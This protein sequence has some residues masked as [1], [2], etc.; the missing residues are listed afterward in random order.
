MSFDLVVRDGTVLDGTGSGPVRA[1]VGIRGERIEAVAPGLAAAGSRVLDAAGLAVAPGFIDIHAHGDVYPLICPDAPARLHDGVT[2]EIIGNCGGSA[3]PQSP[4]MLAERAESAERYGIVVDWATLDDFARRQDAIGSG[5]N[6]GSLVGHGN[7]RTA[8]LGEVDRPATPDELVAMQR[9]VGKALDAGA[10]GFSTGLIYTPGMYAGPEEIEALAGVVARCGA[11]YASH[12]RNEGDAIEQAIEEFASVGR[13]TGV[14]LQLSHAKVAGEP[15]WGKADAVIEQIDGIRAEGIDLA[16]DRYPYS[17]SATSLSALRPGWARAGGR[18]QMLERIAAPASRERIL[19]S[20]NE[21]LRWAARWQ[22]VV[23]SSTY[24][25][26]LR[27]AEGR[28]VHD[29]AQAAGREPA[30]MALE[31]LTAG[32]GRTSIV[33]FSMCEANIAKWYA[34]PYTA[35]GSDSS[36]RS[37]Q[38]PTARGKP[39]P[40]TY[41][42]SA[43]FLGRYVREQGVVPL[44]EGVRRLTGLPASRLGLGRRGVVRAGAY[45]DV[46]VFDPAAIVDRATYERPQQFSEGVRHVVVNGAVALEDGELTGV[47]NGRF[48]RRGAE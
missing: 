27:D 36:T 22:S 40:R 43:R 45:A 18:E 1:D 21:E 28:S 17:A 38:G 46:T 25:E 11:L 5:I 48:L 16:C 32:G 12:I 15:N 31:L 35:V 34:L 37:I 20:L 39:H 42:T 33:V 13:R 10:F 7:V 23:I 14:R 30:E 9:E 6:R 24:A 8:V 3:F 2:T 47:R 4:E 29:L 19:A 26:S 44:A 41:G